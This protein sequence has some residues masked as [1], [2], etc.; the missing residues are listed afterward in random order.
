M[1]PFNSIRKLIVMFG[2]L[3]VA[4]VASADEYQCGIRPFPNSPGMPPPIPEILSGEFENVVVKPF[5]I[6]ILFG[7]TVNNLT[8]TE[9]AVA[10]SPDG[11]GTVILGDVNALPGFRHLA[12]LR[13][14]L[15]F[16]DVTLR[17]GTG[18]GSPLSVVGGPLIGAA[19]IIGNVT[20]ENNSVGVGIAGNT[21]GGHLKIF[22]NSGE[23]LQ[24]SSVVLGGNVVGGNVICSNN[25]PEPVLLF[26]EGA[27]LAPDRA[28][29][30]K[31][32]QCTDEALGF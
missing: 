2:L 23:A 27:L 6:C 5:H 30:E 25:Y 29:G 17:G 32:G 26:Y 8:V 16:G 19:T 10:V 7:A 24:G 13:D 4:S 31:I 12:I 22:N 28:V 21:I 15:V 1:K 20:V 11:N 9:G 14:T 18:P 3:S